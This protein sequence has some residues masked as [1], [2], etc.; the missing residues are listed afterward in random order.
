MP[1]ARRRVRKSTKPMNRKK[2]QFGVRKSKKSSPT[3][4]VYTETY[5]CSTEC[6]GV[7]ANGELFIPA[8]QMGSGFNLVTQMNLLP[9]VAS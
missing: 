6:A 4:Q 2:R 5:K 8:G 3:T 1:F 7:N 9:Q